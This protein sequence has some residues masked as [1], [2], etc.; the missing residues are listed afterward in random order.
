MD[1][2]TLL[3]IDLDRRGSRL[4]V[5]RIGSNEVGLAGGEV[6]HVRLERLAG[7]WAVSSP[8]SGTRGGAL[9][10]GEVLL[11]SARLQDRTHSGWVAWWP[12]SQRRR[13]ER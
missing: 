12:P 1:G 6:A 3:A 4:A 11:G 8:E 5:R 10:N 2:G 9:L 13:T 7:E